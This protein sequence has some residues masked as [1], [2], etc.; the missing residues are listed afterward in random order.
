MLLGGS[1]IWPGKI[2]IDKVHGKREAE[3][4]EKRERERILGQARETRKK[5]EANRKKEEIDRIQNGLGD[6]LFFQH[7]FALDDEGDNSRISLGIIS[8]GLKKTPFGKEKYIEE[9]KQAYDQELKQEYQ[10]DLLLRSKPSKE[11]AQKI[12]QAVKNEENQ[13]LSCS[14]KTRRAAM[15]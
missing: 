4:N 13:L 3:A 7:L 2:L 1:A 14:F 8:A 10:S 6:L 12:L 5:E 11:E 9:L 15:P